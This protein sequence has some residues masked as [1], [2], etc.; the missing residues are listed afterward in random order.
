MTESPRINKVDLITKNFIKN[1]IIYTIA[2]SLP[3]ASAI[4]LL[5]FYLEYLSTEVYGVVALYMGF[6]LLVQIFVTYSFDASIY[7]Y[8]HE[9]K[10]DKEKLATFVS[11]AFTFILIISLVTGI[12]MAIFGGLIFK[13][14]FSESRILF[15]PYGLIAVVTGVFQA[16][17]KV[18]S[19]LLQTQEKASSFLSFNLLSFSLIAS[20]TIGGLYFFPDDLLGPIGGR[21]L[22]VTITGLWALV[23]T[24]R[25]FGFRFDFTLLKGTFSFN[26]P[27]LIYQIMQW[28]NSSYDKVLMLTL[29]LPLSQVGIYDFAAKCLTVVE[30][31]LGGFYNTFF[32]KVLGITALQTK[33]QSTVEINRYF[34]GLTAITILLVT[35]SILGFPIVIEWFVKKPGYLAAL[36]WIP[37][38]AVTYLLR[39]MRYYVSM[40]YASLKYS[41]PLP[42]FYLL[43]VAIKIGSMVV[44]IPKYGVMGLIIATWIGYLV[45]VVILYFGIKNKFEIRFN[46]LKLIVAP[47]TMSLI[48]VIF[49]PMF[50]HQFEF[51]THLLYVVTAGLL[52]AWAYR[53]ELK[54]FDWSSFLKFLK[55]DK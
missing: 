47:L 36:Q 21:F 53:N 48:I 10:N 44:L 14:V 11:S 18:N 30:F 19:S 3:L 49:E 50:G 27:S 34:N 52:L 12:I 4:L 35:L 5:P 25:Q 39:S 17:L 20:L 13:L 45:E 42:F 9:F 40:P 16:V 2:G 22:A 23:V 29:H 33:K 46:A 55:K 37:F 41:K 6:S 32:P 15:Y 31:I 28:F 24:Y 26:H 7:F 1:S 38:I 51:L 54:I 8:F 43:I